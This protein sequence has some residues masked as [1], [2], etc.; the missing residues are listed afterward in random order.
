MILSHQV[1]PSQQTNLSAVQAH[2]NQGKGSS[3]KPELKILVVDKELSS[4]DRN[5]ISQSTYIEARIKKDMLALGLDINKL[6]NYSLE[7]ARSTL[8][9]ALDEKILT[10]G[11]VLTTQAGEVLRVKDIL[12]NPERF[13]LTEIND[14]IDLEGKASYVLHFVDENTMQ[15]EG[16]GSDKQTYT[17]KRELIPIIVEKGE[18]IKALNKTLE[19]L[20]KLPHFFEMGGQIVV[21]KEGKITP[22]TCSYSLQHQLGSAIQYY[23]NRRGEQV[24]ADPDPALL[25]QILS[26]SSNERNLKKLKGVITS[27]VI[28]T[29]NTVVDKGGYDAQANLYLSLDENPLPIPNK[30]EEADVLIALETLMRPFLEFPFASAL[31]KSVGLAA[32]LTSIVRGTLD[33]APAIAFDAPRQGTGKTFL[34]TCIG[35]LGSGRKPLLFPQATTEDEIRKRLLPV[36]MDAPHAILWDNVTTNLNSAALATFLT[37]ES[38]SDRILSKTKILTLPNRSLFL[39]SGNNINISGELARRV[40]ICRLDSKLS[41]PTARS[42]GLNPMDYILENRQKLVQA[43]L[44]LIRGYLTSSAYTSLSY[45]E[46][47]KKKYGQFADW[48]LLVRQTVA[49]IATLNSSY[50]DPISAINQRIENDE[51]ANL[52]ET[53]FQELRGIF[54][55]NTFTS[56]A[57]ADKANAE[58]S[59]G[60]STPTLFLEVL[61]EMLKKK[62]RSSLYSSIAIGRMLASV[63]NRVANNLELEQEQEGKKAATFRVK[64][65]SEPEAL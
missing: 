51:E 7:K 5:T 15:L 9:K 17:L 27:P 16:E 44:I 37:G 8:K 60:E 21:V 59:S 36:L 53:L 54:G 23:V 11:F 26:I 31:D 19:V 14:P 39:I 63:R 3:K 28:T 42:F 52:I 64:L 6:S 12:L 35:L 43:G 55:E 13:H 18:R 57:V 22:I 32:I 34:A 24:K 48:D 10:D 30:I 1:I 25:N 56:K 40:Y 29:D 47:Q 62:T 61:D 46:R 50:V 45:E 2:T 33:T 65:K 20:R 41:N 58:L 38:Y 49:W 4:E